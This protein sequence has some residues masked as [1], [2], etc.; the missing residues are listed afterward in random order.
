M[1]IFFLKK[2][3]NGIFGENEYPPKSLNNIRALNDIIASVD[4][5]NRK[6]W[7]EINE[8]RCRHPVGTYTT[9]LYTSIWHSHIE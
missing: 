9:K 3:D 5:T 8:L 6:C 4:N 7:P 1:V 2:I